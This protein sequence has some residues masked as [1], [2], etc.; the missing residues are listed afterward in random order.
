M[1][2][3]KKEKF[4]LIYKLIYAQFTLIATVGDFCEFSAQLESCCVELQKHICSVVY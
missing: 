1:E 2:E 4:K 3:T